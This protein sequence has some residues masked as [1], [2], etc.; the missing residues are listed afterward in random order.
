LYKLLNNLFLESNNVIVRS[1]IIETAVKTTA[2]AGGN[3]S[4]FTA[5]QLKNFSRGNQSEAEQ[6]SKNGLEKNTKPIETI[7]P[8]TGQKG[9]TVP[10]A[11]KNDGQSTVEV[12]NVKG[13]SLT[14]QLRLQEKF[15]NDNGFKPELLI[16]SGAKISKPLENSSFEIIRYNLLAPLP[17]KD[18]IMAGVPQI[19]K[20][21]TPQSTPTPAPK[22]PA[23]RGQPDA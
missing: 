11:L 2:E 17:Q 4:K 20:E 15:S 23:Q 3:A 12:K 18:G 1:P 8:K 9:T 16:N 13:Q 6:L 22:K 10:D 7:D 5:E 21:N 14:E 19:I